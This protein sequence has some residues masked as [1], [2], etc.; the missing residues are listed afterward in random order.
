MKPFT[1]ILPFCLMLASCAELNQFIPPE[2]LGG[3]SLA[4]AQTQTNDQNASSTSEPEPK[5]VEERYDRRINQAR[6][7]CSLSEAGCNKG[8]LGIGAV[9]IF[10]ALMGNSSGASTSQAQLQQCSNRCDQAKSSCDQ[11]VEALEQEKRQAMAGG[12]GSNGGGAKSCFR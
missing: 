11:N 10:S 4:G 8:C 5:T 7:Q 9:G 12:T 1:F 3:K 2:L 6:Q